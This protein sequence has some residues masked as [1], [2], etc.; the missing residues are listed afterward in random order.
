M[1]TPLLL[2]ILLVGVSKLARYLVVAG[3]VSLF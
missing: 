2:V 1:R 3:A